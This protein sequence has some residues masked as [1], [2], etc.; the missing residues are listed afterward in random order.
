MRDL[1]P[2]D[3]VM[4]T[5]KPQRTDDLRP[6]VAAF[7]GVRRRFMCSGL[8]EEGDY[9]GQPRMDP[10]CPWR[11]FPATWVPLCDLADVENVIP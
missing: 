6:E 11:E 9:Q 7:I 3:Y 5:F 8:V 2:F 4:A 10:V 1:A